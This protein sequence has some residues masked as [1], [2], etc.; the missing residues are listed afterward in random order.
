VSYLARYQWWNLICCTLGYAVCLIVVARTSPSGAYD[1]V[2]ALGMF[3]PCAVPA[4]AFQVFAKGRKVYHVW[5][6]VIALVIAYGS[7]HSQSLQGQ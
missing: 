3:L 7:V 5:T 2:E 4:F 6:F 1:P